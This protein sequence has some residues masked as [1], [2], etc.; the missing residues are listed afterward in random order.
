MA[1]RK[2]WGRTKPRAPEQSM[3]SGAL[4]LCL[5]RPPCV[6]SEPRASSRALRRKPRGLPRVAGMSYGGCVMSESLVLLSDSDLLT[7]TRDLAA[8]ERAVTLRLLVHLNEIERRELHL[9]QGYSSMWD[10]CTAGLGY[11]EPAAFRR[12]RTARCIARFPEIHGLLESGTVSLNSVARVARFLTSE[13]KDDLLARISGRTQREVEGVIAELEPGAASR[14]VVKA[15]VVHIPGPISTMALLPTDSP[16]SAG[17]VG[18]S[19]VGSMRRNDS[20]REIS[21]KGTPMV[22]SSSS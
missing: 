9:K 2:K 4:V 1:P 6:Y 8:L 16:E 14:D 18:G 15:L 21:E 20:M 19:N 17:L 12:I 22:G 7:R 13:N 5:A 11:S 3:R 10:Y